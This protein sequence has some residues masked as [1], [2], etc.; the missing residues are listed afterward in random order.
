M[1]D[2]QRLGR[3]AAKYGRQHGLDIGRAAD[4]LFGQVNSYARTALESVLPNLQLAEEV[5]H[6]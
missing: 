5:A 4:G 1:A 2:M 6:A 3:A